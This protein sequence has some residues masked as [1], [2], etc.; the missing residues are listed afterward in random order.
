LGRYPLELNLFG[1]KLSTNK[2]P[3]EAKRDVGE[4]GLFAPTSAITR[5]TPDNALKIS[6]VYACVR[7]ISESIATLPIN[8]YKT[9]GN[10]REL[11]KEH[12]LYSVMKY[13]PNALM[14]TT[15]LVESF[16]ASALLRGNGYIHPVRNRYGDITELE[17][18]KPKCMT[19]DVS[20]DVPF[21]K[22]FSEKKNATFKFEDI[23][24]FAY[25]TLD[26]VTGISP[27]SQCRTSLELANESEEYGKR[28]FANNAQPGGVIEMEGVLSEEASERF[29]KSWHAGYSG[30]NVGKTALLEGGAKYHAISMSNKDSQ[31]LESKAFSIQDIA[32]MFN[33]PPHL[34]GD[35]SKATFSNIEQQAM[36]FEKYTIRPLVTKIEAIFNKRLLAEDE[37]GRYFFKFNTSALLRGDI[38]TRFE[39]YNIGRNM[40]VYSAND[41]RELEDLN[42]IENGD[43]YLQP[44][45]MVEAGKEG[46]QNGKNVD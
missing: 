6:A 17:F 14:T 40:G 4:S 41:I 16:V 11:A 37:I 28:F 35:L 26:G 2:K 1:L 25:F 27:I 46:E 5:I 9:D 7:L 8:M 12:P 39:A 15:D 30:Q 42:P 19:L 32:R 33:V 24:N 10:K 43:I 18:L 29:K 45:N 22:Y 36:E 44:L 23:V 13:N 3:I 38:K 31:F 21:Y 20:G 34:V